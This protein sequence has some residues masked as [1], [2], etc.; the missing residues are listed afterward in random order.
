MKTRRFGAGVAALV[1]LASFYSLRTLHMSFSDE[2]RFS[3]AF[4][5][6]V[7]DGSDTTFMQNFSTAGTTQN[8][9]IHWRPTGSW[10]QAC[11]KQVEASKPKPF[12]VV[13]RRY[14]LGDCI[15]MCRKC[16]V[17]KCVRHP[18]KAKQRGSGCFEQATR[19]DTFSA[20]YHFRACKTNQHVM[21][22]NW[23]IVEEIMREAQENDATFQE[24]DP[25]ALVL[26]LRLGD[27]IE[28]SKSS[29]VDMLMNGADPW[30]ID[31]Y[32]SAIKSIEE[33]LTDIE[34]SG[35]SQILIRGG[36]HDPN[37]YAK[38]RVYATCLNRAIVT[39]GYDSATMK[40]EGDDP[41]HDF[42]FIS[43]AKHLI[44]STGGYSRLMGEFAKRYGGEFSTMSRFNPKNDNKLALDEAAETQ[45]KTR[46]ALSRIRRQ[47]AET[48]DL[49]ALTLQDLEDQG[50]RLDSVADETGK[51]NDKLNKT[52]KL[53]D[54]FAK[55]SFQ[56][57]TNRAAQKEAREEKK[58]LKKMQESQDAKP[59]RRSLFGSRK[60]KEAEAVATSQDSGA[61]AAQTNSQNES[62]RSELFGKAKGSKKEKGKGK[63]KDVA[64]AKAVD[65]AMSEEDQAMLDD[66]N[67]EDELMDQEIDVLGD[68]LDG[69]M[70]IAS[71][72]G[73][74][75]EKH[76]KKLSEVSNSMEKMNDKQKVVNKRARLFAS[77]RQERRQ[78]SALER[79]ANQAAKLLGS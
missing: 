56:F 41:D 32:Q 14:V 25:D 57:G 45:R 42:Y 71:A 55:W 37:F 40:V 28:N 18:E 46:E 12:Q 67:A 19:N 26:H 70:A 29:V 69:L 59:Q 10:V 35:L 27:V 60:N 11:V 58:E 5:P 30:H 43:H 24:P 2:D 79:K 77:T 21:G 39:A 31:A 3:D 17:L 44:V 15:K 23:T 50:Q 65:T 9:T 48:E 74:E 1:L 4:H 8:T 47:A 72:M 53:Q 13:W 38:S 66:I 63:G 16:Y 61:S 22:G 62:N 78:E 75:T 52:K 6:K 51:L 34:S 36:S 20:L 64:A 33:Y 76:N 68:Q 73:G 54:R 49:G 7:A